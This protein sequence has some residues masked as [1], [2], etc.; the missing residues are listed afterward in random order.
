MIKKIFHKNTAEREKMYI[1]N[2]NK[3]KT[4]ARQRNDIKKSLIGD[5]QFSPKRITTINE[6]KELR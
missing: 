4:E 3:K 5:T 1:N 2:N 6:K